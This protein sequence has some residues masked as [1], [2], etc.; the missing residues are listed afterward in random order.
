MKKPGNLIVVVMAVAVIAAAALIALRPAQ[1]AAAIVRN[2]IEGNLFAASVLNDNEMLAAGELGKVYLS[3][4]SGKTWS[5]VQAPTKFALMDSSFPDERNGWVVG[6]T[7]VIIHTTDGGRTWVKQISGAEST[8][9]GIH[10]LDSMNACVVGADSTVL[11]TADGGATWKKAA[12]PGAEKP[13]TGQAPEQGFNLYGVRMIDT[14]TICVAGYMGRVFLSKDAGQ[15]WSEIKSPLYDAQTQVG[16]TIFS[17][18]G[19]SGSMIASGL[20]TAMAFSKDGGLTWNEVNPGISE[21]EIFGIDIEENTAI[22]AGSAGAV[23]VSSDS[24]MTWTRLETPEKVARAWLA[25][26]DLKKTAS[27][28]KGLIAGQYGIVGIYENGKLSWQIPHIPE[29]Q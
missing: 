16:R 20:D 28:V 29:V 1:K 4:D 5:E 15:T 14:A 18:G 23:L 12:Q 7:G 6:Q 2:Q 21:P 26:A 25:D 9:L 22:A 3:N 10:S 27:G 24:G 8:L 19:G 17:L 11:V 13:A